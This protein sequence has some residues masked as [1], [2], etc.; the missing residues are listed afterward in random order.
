MSRRASPTTIGLFVLGAMALAVIGVSV[1]ASQ[2]LFRTQ[3]TFISYFDESVNGLDV[4]TPVK[5]KG[6]PIGQ[7]SEIQVRLDLQ[8]ETFQ[9][10]VLYRIDIEPVTNTAGQSVNLADP[11]VLQRQV[12]EGLRAQ[13]QMESLLTGKLYVELTFTDDP[14]TVAAV[15]GNASY[16]EVPTLLSPMARIGEEASGLVSDLRRFDVNTINQNLVELLV[17]ANQKV[18]KLNVAAINDSLLQTIRSVRSL[19]EAPEIRRA[20]EDVPRIAA[21]LDTALADVQI[22]ARSL[23]DAVPA[24]S[25]SLDATADE[26]IA[27]LDALQQTMQDTQ[28]M[29]STDSGIGYRVEDAL[30]NLSEAAEALRVLAI[31]LERDPS[32]FI[33][34]KE[35]P[36]TE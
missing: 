8:E 24:T 12:D 9:V 7:V 2:S 5:F 26:L 23:N 11:E 33:R 36:D 21:R 20:M 31:S 29:L 15:E 25:R 3:A 28:Q 19:A 34:G 14:T 27:T 32:M 6:V 17:T 10:P 22:L 30:A 13:L 16:P 4:G 18:D 35:P 1:F